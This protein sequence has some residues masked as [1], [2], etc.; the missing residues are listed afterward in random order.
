MPRPPAIT[1]PPASGQRNAISRPVPQ[2]TKPGH[3]HD[4]ASVSTHVMPNH[5]SHPAQ[6]TGHSGI[7]RSHHNGSLT[8]CGAPLLTCTWISSG[9]PGPGIITP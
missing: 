7:R 1:P 3:D 2:S 4:P 6:I 9:G 5:K 8:R